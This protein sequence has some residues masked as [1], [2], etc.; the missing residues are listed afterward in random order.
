MSRKKLEII[1][2]K[3]ET[4][5]EIAEYLMDVAR[6]GYDVQEFDPHYSDSFPKLRN[7]R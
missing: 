2:L 5:K 1:E 4:Q 3:E 6:K 7:L